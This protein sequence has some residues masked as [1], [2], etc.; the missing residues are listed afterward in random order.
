MNAEYIKEG[1]PQKDR[2]IKLNNG[3]I[4]QMQSLIGNASVKKLEKGL[5]LKVVG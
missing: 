5:G 3:A 1:L 2:L 4:T